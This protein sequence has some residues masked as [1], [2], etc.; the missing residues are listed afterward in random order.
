MKWL[1]AAVLRAERPLAVALVA[2]TLL[3]LVALGVLPP[4][5]V[6]E[7]PSGS[8]SSSGNPPLP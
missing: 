1:I 4:G 3:L 2:V 5:V 8:C 7:P 6:V